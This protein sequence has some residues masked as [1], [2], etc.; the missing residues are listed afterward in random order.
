MTTIEERIWNPPTL[1]KLKKKFEEFYGKDVPFQY[2][3]N[4]EL[5]ND[6]IYLP[7]SKEIK[8]D[9]ATDEKFITYVNYEIMLNNAQVHMD[10]DSP[11]CEK[12]EK[13]EIGEY[14]ITDNQIEELETMN[15]CNDC[16]EDYFNQKYFESLKKKGILNNYKSW[17]IEIYP[18]FKKY[19]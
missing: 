8:V 17:I 6:F 1:K 2:I 14:P 19:L 3:E 13:E 7:N 10:N 16:R 5:D 18:K 12:C 4:G 11:I 9:H 15:K